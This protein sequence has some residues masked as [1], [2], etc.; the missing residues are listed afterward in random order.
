MRIKGAFGLLFLWGQALYGYT[1]KYLFCFFTART[2]DEECYFF[3]LCTIKF[4]EP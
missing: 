1:P 4:Q 3:H 2:V